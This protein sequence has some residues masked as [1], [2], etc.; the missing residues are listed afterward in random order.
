MK[1]GIFPPG[2]LELDLLIFC[3]RLEDIIFQI[4]QDSQEYSWAF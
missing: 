4:Q 3:N 1:A 2:G